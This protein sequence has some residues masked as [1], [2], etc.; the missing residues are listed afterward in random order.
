MMLRDRLTGWLRA[1][2]GN[3]PRRQRCAAIGYVN[4]VLSDGVSLS[5]GRPEGSKNIIIMILF[6]NIQAV[7]VH[8]NMKN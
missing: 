8:N 3:L 2:A 6:E 1:C 7:C 5:D 4:T